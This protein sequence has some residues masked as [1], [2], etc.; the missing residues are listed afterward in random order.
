MDGRDQTG[1]LRALAQV[2]EERGLRWAAIGA[3]HLAGGSG[4][5]PAEHVGRADVLVYPYDA[6]RI[7][8]SAAAR[9]FR[10]SGESRGEARFVFSG[11]TLVMHFGLAPRGWPGFPV[12]PFLEGS[13]VDPADGIRRMGPAAAWAAQRLVNARAL[14]HPGSLSRAQLDWQAALARALDEESRGAWAEAAGRWGAGRLWRRCD[15]LEAWLGG[16]ER[17][18]WLAD[19]VGEPSATAAVPPGWPPLSLAL[20]LQ[21]DLGRRAACLLRWLFDRRG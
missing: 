9:G 15:E 7:R 19:G 13:A 4:R 1:P 17:P 20:A 10:P 8:V 3:L 21:D 11:G 16:G 5:G 14:W 18:A 12:S 6:P 2:L